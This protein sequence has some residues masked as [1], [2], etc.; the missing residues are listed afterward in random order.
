MT[1]D[2]DA[3]TATGEGSDSLVSIEQVDG[4][5]FDDTL[6][7]DNGANGFFGLSGADDLIGLGDDDFLIGGPGD[8]S[9]DGGDGDDFLDG[10]G[11]T[12]TCTIGETVSNCEA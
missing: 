1:V 6:V 11:G 8:D 10:K 12:D 2:L 7:G 5:P 9:L 4:S 3:G